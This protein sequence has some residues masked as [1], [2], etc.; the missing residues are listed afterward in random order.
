MSSDIREFG[1]LGLFRLIQQIGD[2]ATDIS[3]GNIYGS[4]LLRFDRI[5]PARI[6]IC[7]SANWSRSTDNDAILRS[8]LDKSIRTV[9]NTESLF[10]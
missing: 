8:V 4:S 2:H 10:S 1:N 7:Q 3:L 6:S 9:R 5:W